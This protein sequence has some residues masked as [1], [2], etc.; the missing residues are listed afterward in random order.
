MQKKSLF[1]EKSKTISN[2]I[3]LIL[4]VLIFFRQGPGILNNFKKEGTAFPKIQLSQINNQVIELPNPNQKSFLVFW[5]TWCPPCLVELN[6]INKA[7]KANKIN[8]KDFIAINIG[9]SASKVKK[10]LK[11]NDYQFNVALDPH[12][13]LFNQIEAQ[14]TPTT[15]LINEKGQIH[16]MSTGLKPFLITR[17]RWFLY[18]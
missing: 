15:V 10:F 3:F 14:G 17:L 2:I 12:H 11:Q 5:A 6:Q 13:K 16:S 18:D 8:S 4:L 1:K 7:I 9:E